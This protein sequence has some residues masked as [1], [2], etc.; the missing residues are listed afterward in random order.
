MYPSFKTEPSPCSTFKGT[1]L[2]KMYLFS[3]VVEN[4]LGSCTPGDSFEYLTC[5]PTSNPRGR[6]KKFH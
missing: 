3:K 6:T 4:M 5:D 2:T 1:K